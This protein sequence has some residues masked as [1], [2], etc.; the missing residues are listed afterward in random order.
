MLPDASEIPYPKIS[1]PKRESDNIQCDPIEY[2]VEKL[3]KTQRNFIAVGAIQEEHIEG[4]WTLHVDSD[5]K[6][7]LA[8][9]VVDPKQPLNITKKN[10]TDLVCE[11][12]IRSDAPAT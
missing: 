8:I 10:A 4:D 3:K 5:P 9:T 2:E 12:L 11:F 6:N 7:N 1:R